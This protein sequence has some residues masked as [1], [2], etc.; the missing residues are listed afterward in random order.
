MAN[1]NIKQN[2]DNYLN[3]LS[4]EERAITIAR[5]RQRQKEGR[6]KSNENKAKVQSLA[7]ITKALG[8]ADYVEFD[9][10]SQNISINEK[11]VSVAYANMIRNP[12]TTFKEINEVQKV[13]NNDTDDGKGALVVNFITQGQDLGD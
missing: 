12:K 1:Y 13:I 7:E 10:D 4:D 3:S 11:C 5:W 2:V 6:A 8:E 9:D